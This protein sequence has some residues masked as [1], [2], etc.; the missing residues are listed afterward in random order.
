MDD[1]KAKR[2]TVLFI[3]PWVPAAQRPRSYGLLKA[4]LEEYDVI[5]VLQTWSASDRREA[6]ALSDISDHLQVISVNESKIK[7]AFRSALALASSRSLQ[8]SYT[9]SRRMLAAI[10]KQYAKASPRFSYFN[11]IRSAQYASRVPGPV[12][13]DLDEFRSD[14][15]AQM[16]RQ[17]RSPL[18]RAVG[19]VEARRMRVAEADVLRRFDLV[20]VSSPAEVRQGTQ[21]VLIRSPHTLLV[22]AE[23]PRRFPTRR[24][25]EMLFVGR[26]SYR[27][28]F[29]AVE[30]LVREVMPLVS[31][32]RHEATLTVVGR[33]PKRSVLKLNSDKVRIVGSVPSVQPYYE[34]ASVSLV[35]IKMATGIQMK[36]I[37]S[38][39]VGTPIVTT[40]V[41]AA[42]AGLEHGVHCLVADTP[43][44]WAAAVDQIMT[45]DQLA[46]ELA[47]AAQE[48]SRQFSSVKVR[49]SLLDV[50]ARLNS[51]SM[52]ESS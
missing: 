15:Y 17:S 23:E 30:W 38:A 46:H 13:I 50:V 1:T 51:H 33:D 4:L 34:A 22:S 24:S 36:L 40:S 3:A 28:N 35:P 48:W 49:S 25:A 12:A 31:Q 20:L 27:A 8:Q 5:A 43:S 7:G 19:T 16:S 6:E 9:N 39:A 29:E 11:V 42:R 52:L 44:E 32:R 41:A 45:D 47:M 10:E 21:A 2:D 14:Y 26:L 37:E 18:W